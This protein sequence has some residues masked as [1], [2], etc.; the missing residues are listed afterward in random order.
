MLTVGSL[1]SGAG[2]CDLGLHMAGF[3]HKFFCDS[4]AFCRSILARHWPDVP[5]Y[6]DVRDVSGLTAPKVDVLAGGFPC[7][8]VSSAGGRRGIKQGTRSGLWYEYARIISEMRPRYAI[9]ENVKGLLSNGIW[10]VLSELA[11]IGY[12]AEWTCLSAAAVGAPH[13]R[14]RIFIVAYPDCVRADGQRGYYLRS[15]ETWERTTSL[16]AALIGLEFRLT[17]RQERPSGRFMVDVSFA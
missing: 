12:D 6:K 3:K 10:V 4:D 9:I 7:Q 8:D 1:F 17:G 11:A 13:I 16:G 14:Q 15:R 2:L 5:I